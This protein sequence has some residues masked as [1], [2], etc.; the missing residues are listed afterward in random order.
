ME[1]HQ[2]NRSPYEAN[3]YLVA[4]PKPVLIDVGMNARYVIDRISQVMELTDIEIIILTHAHFDHWGG[5]EEVKRSTG[6][7]IAIHTA[8]AVLL[9]DEVSNVA[10]MFGARDVL[11]PDTVLNQDDC[12]HLGGGEGLEVLHTPG[13]TPGSICL[14]H[15]ESRSLFSGDTVFPGGGFG[16]TDLTGGSMV[17]LVASLTYLTGLEVGTMYPGHGNVVSGNVEG[18]IR[19][20]LRLAESYL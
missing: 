16:R 17:Q 20:S 4:A 10:S 14:Y 8:D 19:L 18:Q 13:H 12:I 7:S 9:Q 6:A 1:V 5:V 2:I 15:P 3:A 11:V